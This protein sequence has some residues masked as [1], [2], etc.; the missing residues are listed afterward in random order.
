MKIKLNPDKEIVDTVREGLRGDK[1][2]VSG[3][4]GS[5]CRP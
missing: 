1:M 5:D 2:Y 3:V 4:Q